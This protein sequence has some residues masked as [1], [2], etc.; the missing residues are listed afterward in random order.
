MIKID[1]H[2]HFWKFDPVR[3]SWINEE[4]KVLRKD[5]LPDDFYSILEA[6]EING[7]VAVQADQSLDETRF[8]LNQAKKN[9]W[10]KGVIG[11]IDLQSEFLENDLVQLEG[12]QKLKGFRHIAQAEANDFLIS[13]RFLKGLQ[14]LSKTDYTY[15]ILVFPPQLPAAIELVRKF[16]TQK[17]IVDHLAKPYINKGLIKEWKQNIVELARAE[18]VYCKISGMITEADWGNWKQTDFH[19]YLDVVTETFGTKRL[20]FGSDYPVCLLAGSYGQVLEIVKDYFESFSESE[21]EDIFGL[22]AIK[23]YN[24]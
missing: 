3:D 21:K 19:P 8:L 24:L 16:P 18:N 23:F 13:N 4:M 10:I 17:F 1:A 14:T 9:D 5:F 6:N 20:M 12:E 7:S 11:W 15:D 2:N 22:N